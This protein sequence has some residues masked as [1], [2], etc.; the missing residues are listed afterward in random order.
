MRPGASVDM[1]GNRIQNV[2]NGVLDSDAANMGQLRSVERMAK[3]QGAIAA[4][5]VNIPLPAATT[6][7]E[8]TVGA[9]IGSSGGQSA[10]AIGVAS[11]LANG[12][13]IK[14]TAGVSGS[15]KSVGMGVGFTFK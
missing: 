1:G 15:T 6:P 9:A 10:L 14:G 5:A 2:G 4:A 12:L 3:Q 7:G 11:R 13:L 8:T